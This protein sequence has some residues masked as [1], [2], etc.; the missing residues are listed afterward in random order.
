MVSLWAWVEVI[1][2]GGTRVHVAPIHD[3]R[4][5]A[6]RIGQGPEFG[7]IRGDDAAQW[8]EIRRLVIRYDCRMHRPCLVRIGSMEPGDGPFLY[9]DPAATRR[10]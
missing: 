7:T 3:D 5:L 8:A 4:V 1:A 2:N 9:D 10:V 6:V